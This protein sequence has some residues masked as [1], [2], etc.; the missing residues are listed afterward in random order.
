M[1]RKRTVERL[2]TT[3]SNATSDLEPSIN[4]RASKQLDQLS[5]SLLLDDL[6]LNSPEKPLGVVSAYGHRG[7]SYMLELDGRLDYLFESYASVLHHLS[8]VVDLDVVR[9]RLDEKDHF[10][11][12]SFAALVLSC[13]AMP[14]LVPNSLCYDPAK[15]DDVIQES[16]RLHHSLDLGLAPTLDTLST[17]MNIAA[18]ARNRKGEAAAFL[19]TK[20]SHGIVELLRLNTI[21]GYSGL[22]P[23]ERELALRMFWLL[24]AAERCVLKAS[25]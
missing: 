22:Q 2:R 14:L 13:V 20:E 11:D 6:R 4:P 16:I 9:K 21:D 10:R 12:E 7:T 24:A 23:T 25:S 15:A 5:T 17:S 8:P 1:L 18:Y 19:R 3:L